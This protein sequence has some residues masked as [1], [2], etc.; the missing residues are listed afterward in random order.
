MQ[1]GRISAVEIHADNIPEPG[2]TPF[3]IEGLRVS[4]DVKRKLK[5]ASANATNTATVQIWNLSAETRARLLEKNRKVLLFA[6]YKDGEGIELLFEGTIVSVN[7]DRQLPDVVTRI[8]SHDGEGTLR[9]AHLSK[10][11]KE[12]AS[13]SQILKDV[14]KSLGLPTSFVA[15]F[16]D[17]KF[18]QGFAHHG[19]A[20]DAMDKMCKSLGLEWSIQN[21]FTQVLKQNEPDNTDKALILITDKSGLIGS[22]ER[23]KQIQD[24]P[25]KDKN[26]NGYTIKSLL[27]PRL[28]PGSHVAVQ[29]RE[30]KLV[31]SFRVE[32]VN[33]KG[34][35]HGQDWTSEIEV[36]DKTASVV[37]G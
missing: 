3:R 20:K 12:G 22:P 4:F 13:A 28:N 17:K 37:A 7:H 14:I 31:T 6:G 18:L 36:F 19:P 23:L 26:P 25:N 9:T 21:G 24:D 16:E 34:D 33:H 2:F 30:I 27:Q 11:Y 8:E 5:T 32:N 1:F 35:T 15:K 10:S 29:S